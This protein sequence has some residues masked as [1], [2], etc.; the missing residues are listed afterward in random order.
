MNKL[1]FLFSLF[2]VS[3]NSPI[4]AEPSE[5]NVNATASALNATYRVDT[6]WATAYQA[7]VTL[8][9]NTSVS[10]SSWSA[11]FTLPQ[12]YV[13]SS[14]TLGGVF[15]VQGQNVTVKN[16]TGNGVI[17]PGQSAT[18]NMIINMPVS[19][20]T[21]I[22]N[23]QA[24]ADGTVPPPETVPPAPILNAIKNNHTSN[25]KVSWSAS[26]NA[27]S[28]TLQQSTTSNFANPTVFSLGNSLFKSFANMPA[29]T[30]FYRVQATNTAGNSAFS[31]T[32]KTTITNSTPPT[33]PT[34]PVLNVISNDSTPNY[35]VFWS[36]SATATSYTLQQSTSSNFSNPTVFSLGNVLSKSF[37][38]QPA[39]TYY[40][41]VL[42]TN[43]TG[44]S[45][46]SNTQNT[47]VTNSTPVPP[48]TA[49]IEHSAWY[50]DWTSWFNGPPFVIPTNNNVLNIFVG[51][52]MFGADGKPTV[53]GF[54][55]MTLPQMD[56]FTAYCAAQNPPIGV[57]VSIGGA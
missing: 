37:T 35:S 27:T 43:A 48:I 1:L 39:G 3:L 24:V 36:G 49:E 44:N 20:A 50:I 53:G 12:N 51:T 11:T 40:Y 45:P 38:D 15:T 33:V 26:T 16:A 2:I 7:T 8:T 34:A 46:F 13:L 10:T 21:V 28:Y 6:V 14:H 55:N 52:L 23:L 54:G 32:Q 42:A 19:S 31:K 41:R 25:Y 30:Y 47:T 57:K 29:G 22:N 56:A 17:A 9:N 5:N 18:F 4:N